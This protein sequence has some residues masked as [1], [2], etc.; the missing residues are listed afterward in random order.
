M[1]GGCAR[2]RTNERE[3]RGR[4]RWP[5]GQ[6]V[7]GLWGPEG[8]VRTLGRLRRRWAG[9]WWSKG[10]SEDRAVGA[11]SAVG[12]GQ[13]LARVRF[14]PGLTLLS[15]PR[16]LSARPSPELRPAQHPRGGRRCPGRLQLHCLQR[17]M[18]E[19]RER[20]RGAGRDQAARPEQRQSQPSL[21]EQLL[22]MLLSGNKKQKA[23]E[24]T[25]CPT[26]GGHRSSIPQL[27]SSRQRAAKSSVCQ[28]QSILQGL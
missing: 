18:Q 12:G 5:G 4:G 28:P 10:S 2:P 14:P 20:S 9:A 13:V 22:Q 7:V 26:L 19:C 24:R 1:G 21:A 25:I 27:W 11:G 23:E 16:A 8:D 17:W 3:G 6:A 15:S